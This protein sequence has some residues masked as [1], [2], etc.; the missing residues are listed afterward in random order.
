LKPLQ[1]LLNEKSCSLNIDEENHTQTL[2]LGLYDVLKLVKNIRKDTVLSCNINFFH[3]TLGTSIRTLADLFS[4]YREELRFIKGLLNTNPWPS[5]LHDAEYDI[6]FNDEVCLGLKMAY[7]HNSFVAS[8]NYEPWNQLKLNAKKSF[9][10]NDQLI[11][12]DIDISNLSNQA[13]VDGWRQEIISYGRNVASSSIVKEFDGLV[14]RMWLNDHEPPHIHVQRRNE[15]SKTIAKI[16]ILNFD[17]LA[18]NENIKET[19]R[20]I[21]PWLREN[22]DALNLSWSRCRIGIKPL[23]ID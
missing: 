15:P 6:R 3:I 12:E 8:F 11:E 10:D 9:L 2:L 5:T 13:H 19:N 14:I 20:I 22:K 16:D 1:I 17:T 18:E 4:P 21:K 7:I 23:R